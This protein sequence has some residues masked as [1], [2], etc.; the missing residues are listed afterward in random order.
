M[1]RISNIKIYKDITDEEVLFEIKENGEIVKATM[2]NEKIKIEVP[3]TSD[4][5]LDYIY[6]I[7]GILCVGGVGVIIYDKKRKK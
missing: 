6:I 7:A 1:R 2:T 3:N 4:N 5:S